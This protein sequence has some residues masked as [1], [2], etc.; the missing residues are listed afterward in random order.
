MKDHRAHH[1]LVCA[2]CG[3][4]DATVTKRALNGLPIGVVACDTCREAVKRREVGVSIQPDGSLSITDGRL[5]DKSEPTVTV[6]LSIISGGQWGVD[7]GA[8]LAGRVLGLETGG[9]A[10]KGWMTERGSMPSLKEFGLIEWHESGYPARTKANVQLGDATLIIGKRSAGSNLTSDLCVQLHKPWLWVG[11]ITA[12]NDTAM[13]DSIAWVK[14][15]LADIAPQT[16]NCAGN[17]ESVSPG[18][19]AATV[20]FLTSVLR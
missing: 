11:D 16:L 6:T 12:L 1:I 7:R 4:P 14:E 5:R 15:W 17:R 2:V 10:A 18:I 19:E 3:W 8:L 13:M 9:Y 20:E